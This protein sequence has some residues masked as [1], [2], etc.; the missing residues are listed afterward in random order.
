M[1]FEPDSSEDIFDSQAS[2]LQSIA[3]NTY[4]R[5][6]TTLLYATLQSVAQTQAEQQQDIKNV[7]DSA[8]IEDASGEELTKK[9]RNLGVLRQSAQRATG[10]VTFERDSTA[11]QDY[12]IQSGTII[13]TVQ[14]DPVQFETTETVTLS[15]GTSSV[16]ANIQATTGGAAGNVASGAIQAM[17]SKPTGVDTVTNNQKTGDPTLTD[18]NGDP[19]VAGQP[20]EDDEALRE[21]VLDTDAVQQGPDPDGIKLALQSVEGVVSTSVKTN[22]TSS[23]VN[24][25]DPYHSEF[26]VYGGAVRD[27][28][29]KLYETVDIGTFLRL[30]GGVN[31]SKETYTITAELLGQDVTVPI[32]RPTPVNID[33]AIDVV[34]TETFDGTNPVK[35]ELVGYVGGTQTDNTSVIGRRGGENL[36]INE[37]E[38][39]VEDL[40]G[41]I[42][43][44]IT[45]IDSDS[46]GTDDRTTSSNGVPILTVADS[47]VSRLDASNVTVSTNEQ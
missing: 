29:E 44:D 27:I 25:I 42:Y 2:T 47:E 30:Q 40:D 33:V 38:N 20:Q 1:S 39:R 31:G 6:E 22:Q 23:P 5:A 37:M 12:T 19:L 41:V 35:D 4:P 18:T 34:H 24:G 7:Y 13:E 8:Y 16:D 9:A 46:D 36:R 32:T 28:V 10:V 11:T 45:L 3:P 43:A 17:P 14:N 26:I 15:N 21:R